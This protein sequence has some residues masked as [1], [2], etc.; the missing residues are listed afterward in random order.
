M[1]GVIPGEPE[2]LIGGGG[3]LH[4]IT[5]SNIFEMRNF[6]RDKD[7]VEWKIRSRGLVRHATRILLQGEDLK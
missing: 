6:L 7:V 4:A 2:F 5:S 1:D 3:E